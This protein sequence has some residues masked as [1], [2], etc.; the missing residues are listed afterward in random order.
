MN[1]GLV[2][3]LAGLSPYWRLGTLVPMYAC[4]EARSGP[5]YQFPGRWRLN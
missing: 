2:A 3:V 4:A 1:G 5:A